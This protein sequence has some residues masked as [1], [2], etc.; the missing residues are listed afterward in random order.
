MINFIHVKPGPKSL[1]VYTFL[2]NESDSDLL[3]KPAVCKSHKHSAG[4]TVTE[5]FCYISASLLALY[6]WGS[7]F[8][9]PLFW[10]RTVYSTCGTVKTIFEGSS[11]VIVAKQPSGTV[12]QWT[13]W[14]QANGSHTLCFFYFATHCMRSFHRN[15]LWRQPCNK[16][17]TACR[18]PCLSG[19][20]ISLYSLLL[21]VWRPHCHCQ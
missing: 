8:T 2:H 4:A 6:P 13:L 3:I 10:V 15:C 5:T 17:T 18:L 21:C 9:H 12:P 19:H 7:S 14:F 1:Y 16:G 11:T 20:H